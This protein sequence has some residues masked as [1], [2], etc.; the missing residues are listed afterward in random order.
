MSTG[1]FETRQVPASRIGT[2]DLGRIGLRKHHVAGLLEVDVTDVI[3]QLRARRFEG[4]RVSF[5]AWMTKTIGDTIA[6]NRYIHALR[7]GKRRLLV[8]DD[9]DV[10]IMV[11]KEI[12][13]ERVPIPLLIRKTNRKS[14]AD[15]HDEIQAARDRIVEDES[16]YVM[17][18]NEFPRAVMRLYYALPQWFRVCLIRRILRSPHRSKAM[19]G[20][21][22][23]TTVGAAGHL[24]GWIIPKSMH[25]LCFALGAITKKP[26]IVA[27]RI[28]IRDIL[29]LTVLVDHD[30]VDG[31]PASRFLARLVNRVQRGTS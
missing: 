25:N 23:I 9:I 7:R 27:N 10:S 12:G 28:E 8:F 26:W 20:T 19:M 15:I 6:E 30:A 14:A 2:I 1:S 13:G 24:S 16:D 29:H 31:I 17:T 22:V 4:R 11:E 5:F 21:A 3:S 18:E